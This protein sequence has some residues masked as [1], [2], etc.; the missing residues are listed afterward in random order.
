M[1]SNQNYIMDLREL[2]N[3][4]QNL[5][6]DRNQIREIKE[7]SFSGLNNLL[8]LD[9]NSNQITEIKENSFS[10]LKFKEFIDI[11]VDE[12]NTRLDKKIQSDK[13]SHGFT[14]GP[15]YAQRKIYFKH[16]SVFI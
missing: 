13:E 9:L 10:D 2:K 4:L 3:N 16:V 8:K 14:D 15:A 7:N 1:L 11:I 6:L 12:T 5:Y